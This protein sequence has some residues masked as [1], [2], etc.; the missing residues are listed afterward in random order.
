MQRMDVVV[1]GSIAMDLIATVPT[2]PK[3]NTTMAAL[4][5]ETKNGGKGA[6][7]AVAVARLGIKVRMVG[8]V[9]NDLF[10]KSL[11]LNLRKDGIDIEGVVVDNSPESESTGM[12][13]IISSNDKSGKNTIACLGANQMC[14]KAELAIASRFMRRCPEIGI[15][16]MQNE[17]TH[18]AIVRM[19]RLG[20][21]SRKLVV[22]K[23]SP[24]RA[25]TDISTKLYPKIDVLVV[26]EYEAPILLLS[27]IHI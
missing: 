3:K 24:I 25:A 16:L 26:N 7:E 12:S 8:R 2:H 22:F 19:A 6:N 11:C 1:F 20:H 13:M 23:A 9:K 15:V 27:L 4:Q 18:N 17:I 10:G 21:N 14:G 5:L